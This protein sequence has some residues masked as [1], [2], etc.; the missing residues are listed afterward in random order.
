MDLHTHK[1]KPQA[2]TNANASPPG[3][4]KDLFNSHFPPFSSTPPPVDEKQGAP[5]YSKEKV[6]AL[7]LQVFPVSLSRPRPPQI[8]Q[9]T[10][11]VSSSA[12]LTRFQDLI[13]GL[14]AQPLNVNMR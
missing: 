4:L 13:S 7:L 12:L 10:T 14:R 5:V 9:T 11:R 6:E 8:L 2:N 1:Y 3:L